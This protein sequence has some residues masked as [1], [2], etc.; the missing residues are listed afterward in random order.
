MAK[1]SIYIPD[2]L[3]V[4]MDTRPNLNWSALAQR[5]FELEIAST[6]KT[7]NMEAVIERLKASKRRIEEE[8]KP[9]W[10]NMGREW[11]S[12]EA[13]FR[14][15]KRVANVNGWRWDV[16]DPRSGFEE[17]G[18]LFDAILEARNGPQGALDRA[19]LA[20][21]LLGD[22]FVGRYPGDEQMIW[23][24]QGVKEVWDAVKD[25]V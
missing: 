18:G 9:E 13:E 15:L 12:N 19:G 23:Y 22:D 2:E 4:R 7:G 1:I 21:E 10:V 25:H 17:A 20:Y 16:N 6:G 5:S 8:E 24:L 14:E 11:A 3:K